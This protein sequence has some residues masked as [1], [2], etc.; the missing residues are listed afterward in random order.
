[1]R[2]FLGVFPDANTQLRLVAALER[3][4]QGE[5][6]SFAL[7]WSPEEQLHITLRF[8]GERDESFLSELQQRLP[9]FLRSEQHFRIELDG[10]GAFARP[11]R[12]RV[13]FAETKRGAAEL[14]ALEA[15]L[16]EHLLEL[17]VEPES[18]DFHP[19]LTLARARRAALHLPDLRHLPFPALD[20]HCDALRLMCS[21]LEASGARY[22]TLAEFPLG[23]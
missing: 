5:L 16:S 13:L 6:S 1:V 19:H 10:L 7:R 8:L 2:L 18:R 23:A 22:E 12:A 11:E 14:R 4:R 9:E 17:D 15:R 21:H 20:W 3:L